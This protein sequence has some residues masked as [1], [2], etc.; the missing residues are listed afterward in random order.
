MAP[1]ATRNLD[2]EEREHEKLAVLRAAIDAGDASGI[3]EGDVFARVR[4]KLNLPSKG[5]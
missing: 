3:S 1:S 2:R 5:R 4:E